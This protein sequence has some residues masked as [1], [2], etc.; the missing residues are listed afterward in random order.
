MDLVMAC[1]WRTR[2]TNTPC[3]YLVLLASV[4]LNILHWSGEGHEHCPPS[5][6]QQHL[7]R[8]NYPCH[9]RHLPV[10][11]T[12]ILVHKTMHSHTQFM[13]TWFHPNTQHGADNLPVWTWY[14]NLSPSQ[15]QL[16]R[17]GLAHLEHGRP[18]A[19][20]P[21]FPGTQS[22]CSDFQGMWGTGPC[23]MLKT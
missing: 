22:G 6:L 16:H 1:H 10:C 19:T 7:D 17:E 14:Q 21:T 3:T 5:Y 20:S 11:W 23:G 15:P 18:S 9:A 2:G 8:H 13:C 12:W 4:L